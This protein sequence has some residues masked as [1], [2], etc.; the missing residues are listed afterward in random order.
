MELGTEKRDREREERHKMEEG[1]EWGGIKEE[2]KYGRAKR[3]AKESCYETYGEKLEKDGERKKGR[4]CNK[5]GRQD[6]MG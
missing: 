4:Q 2:G 5:R 1:G 3:E 6:I